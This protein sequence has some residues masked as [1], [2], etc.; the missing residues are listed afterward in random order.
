MDMLIND[1][2][3]ITSNQN[4]RDEELT[5]ITLEIFQLLLTDTESTVTSTITSDKTSASNTK[6][7][8]DDEDIL[9]TPL[10]T[11]NIILKV[12][13]KYISSTCIIIV[14]VY[15][16]MYAYIYIYVCI[17]VDIKIE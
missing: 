4:P 12:I 10:D 1:L 14:C 17:H 11:A 8:F 6:K 5:I 3:E 9:V 13:Y 2:I 15:V 16:C 7:G